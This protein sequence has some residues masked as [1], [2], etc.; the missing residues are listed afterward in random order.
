M[1][2]DQ[3]SGTHTPQIER[4]ARDL[5]VKI[6]PCVTRRVERF[7]DRQIKYAATLGTYKVVVLTGGR[8]E[9]IDTV[10]HLYLFDLAEFR[11]KHQVTVNGTQADI[12]QNLTYICV[13][14]IRC[15]MILA[16]LQEIH[17]DRAL[18]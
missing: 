4:I 2:F 17:D 11:S 9:V 14:H 16:I 10:A 1:F 5:S 13:N 6:R 7:P 18:F 3:T 15:R 12:G 8:I